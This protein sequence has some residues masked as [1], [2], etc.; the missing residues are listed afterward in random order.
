MIY[1]CIGAIYN[2]LPAPSNLVRWN[3][4]KDTRC[5]LCSKPSAT[6]AHILGACK[7]ALDQ[8]RFTYRH[9]SVLEVFIR[10]V[11]DFLLTYKPAP[12]QRSEIKFVP[13]GYKKSSKVKKSSIGILH[14][15]SDWQ[16]LSDLGTTLVV[17]PYLAVT[18]LR[19][20]ILIISKSTRSVIVLELTCPCEENMET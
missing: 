7:I 2:T 3:L 14:Y 16:V 17:P 10:S 18:R 5:P 11:K 6:I 15:A 4:S 20:D 1:F 12:C 19:P 8:G 13:E 9:D